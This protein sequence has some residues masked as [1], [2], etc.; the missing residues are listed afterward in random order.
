LDLID[1]KIE[2][3]SQINDG[4]CENEVEQARETSTIDDR[5]G[6]DAAL[7]LLYLVV[8]AFE[9]AGDLL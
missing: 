4:Y 1:E 8:I 3:E 5:G 2:V 9:C 6:N 7:L